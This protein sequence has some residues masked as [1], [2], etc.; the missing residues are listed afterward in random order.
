MTRRH[1]AATLAAMK[2][3]AI[4]IALGLV[5]APLT[6]C[7]KGE[8]KKAAADEKGKEG[9]DKD[10][11]AGG[12]AE[13]AKKDGGG[14]KS[15][16]ATDAMKYVPDGANLVIGLDA[17]KVAASPVFKDNEA[18]LKEGDAGEMMAAAEACKVGMATWK[19]A[20]IAGN[21]EKDD[22]MVMVASAAGLGKKE[23]LDCIAKKAKE[24]DPEADATVTEEDGM[25]V[26]KTKDDKSTGYGV[27][28]DVFVMAGKD[29][30]EAV[31]ALI[32]G[33]GKTAQ[34]GSLKD[35]LAAAD[36][37][38]HIYFAMV[39]TADMQKGPTEGL[40]H[41]TGGIDL[42]AGLALNAAADFGDAE[43]A[44]A[45]AGEA[46]KQFGEMKGMAGMLGIPKPVVDSV[47]IEAKGTAVAASAKATAEDLKAMSKAAQAQMKGG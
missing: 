5:A 43:K 9:G 25:V 40:K 23:T 32:G 27:S 2:R 6:G 34:D 17:A 45:V 7:D 11:K 4:G 16:G 19:Y 42:S 3:L 12:D 26:V 38:S 1:P 18:L 22:G 47:K 10:K 14:D 46:N 44:K 13:K 39:A 37:S 30:N 20:V 33:S 36:R 41:I 24:K 15:A 31:K 8:E 21:T 35:V 29:Y 28:D